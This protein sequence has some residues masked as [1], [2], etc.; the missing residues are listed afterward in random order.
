MI[1]KKEIGL[2]KA[3]KALLFSLSLP[4][5]FS[6]CPDFCRKGKSG[7]AIGKDGVGGRVDTPKQYL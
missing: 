2:L 5:V 1:A 3:T 7:R 4:S 6:W